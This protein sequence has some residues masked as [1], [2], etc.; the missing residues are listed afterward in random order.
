MGVCQV[1][2]PVGC[3]CFERLVGGRNQWRIEGI[4]L[5]EYIQEAYRRA[6]EA[7]ADLPTDLTD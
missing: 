3:R 5:E 2:P 1:Q 6:G 4:K 7:L